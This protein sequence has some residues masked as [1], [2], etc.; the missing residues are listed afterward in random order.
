M[1]FRNYAKSLLQQIVHH[2]QFDRKWKDAI[3][4]EN[5]VKHLEKII[6]GLK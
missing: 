6:S 5:K 1:T 4:N 2:D 3:Q